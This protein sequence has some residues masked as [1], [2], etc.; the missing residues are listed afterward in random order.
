MTDLTHRNKDL[1]KKAFLHIFSCKVSKHFAFFLNCLSRLI[2]PVKEYRKYFLYHNIVCMWNVKYLGGPNIINTYFIPLY[3]WGF[4]SYYTNRRLDTDSLWN[5]R[6][7]YFSRPVK[8]GNN[9]VERTLNTHRVSVNWHIRFLRI[10]LIGQ[11]G[12]AQQINLLSR[13]GI[14]FPPYPIHLLNVELHVDQVQK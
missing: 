5:K 4:L 8:I 10:S 6:N 12:D 2:Q 13:Y 7:K 14:R 3:P 1:W 9:H 11:Q